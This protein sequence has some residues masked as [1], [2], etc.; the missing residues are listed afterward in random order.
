MK[1]WKG[2]NIMNNESLDNKILD[3]VSGKMQ[4]TALVAFETELK[5]NAAL[6]NEV[7]ETRA[8]YLLFAS[9]DS[10]D[11]PEPEQ[12][13]DDNFYQMLDF[14]IKKRKRFWVPSFKKMGLLM[15]PLKPVLFGAAMLVT[16]IF[17]GNF[18][19]SVHFK[20]ITTNS[21]NRLLT[22]KNTQMQGL[23][24]VAMLQLPSVSKRLQAVSLVE[25]SNTVDNIVVKALFNTLNNDSNINV[26]LAVLYTLSQFSN[27]AQVREGLVNAIIHQDSPMVQ[28]AIAD[29]MLKLQ[30]SR[31]IKPFKELLDSDALIKPARERITHTVNQLI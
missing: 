17:I 28:I 18:Y 9:M 10:Q 31:A 5:N 23:A 16:G 7:K 30:E 25:N 3:Y 11:I 20:T 15:Q 6:K 4:G 12:S 1:N 19:T 13:M 8:A 24:V 14:K 29:L 27:T 2:V 21:E 26:R 22:E